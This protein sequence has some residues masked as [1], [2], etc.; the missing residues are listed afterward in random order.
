MQSTLPR[1]DV[2][3]QYSDERKKLLSD[4]GTKLNYKPGRP[5]SLLN[6][7]LE[8]NIVPFK[9]HEVELFKTKME[10]KTMESGTKN[11][12]IWFTA[13]LAVL[14]FFAWNMHGDPSPI[15]V[16][17][18]VVGVVGMVACLLA[19]QSMCGHGRR[20]HH[21]W[22]T[23]DISVYEGLI[24]DHVLNKAVQIKDAYKPSNESL[25][26]QVEALVSSTENK[27]RPEPDPFL[28]VHNHKGELYY[29]EQWDEKDLP[30]FD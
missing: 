1:L 3:R 7:L 24:P 20:T 18:S 4:A 14:G 25:F 29:I 22:K 17:T 9:T 5:D 21:L 10:K 8:L 16:A 12:A 28:V 6:C 2:E 11:W 13:Q 26:F 27:V 15:N 23:Y 30:R 19:T